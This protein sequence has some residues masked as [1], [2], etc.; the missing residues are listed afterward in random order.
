MKR[1]DSSRPYFGEVQS[2]RPFKPMVGPLTP[3]PN[4]TLA[5]TVLE[6][7]NRLCYCPTCENERLLRQFNG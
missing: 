4:K 2:P 5:E 3:T 7:E 6:I 1:F